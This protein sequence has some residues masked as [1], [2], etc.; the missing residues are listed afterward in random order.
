M[1][2]VVMGELVAGGR[3][4]PVVSSRGEACGFPI[5]RLTL[6][7]LLF[8]LAGWIELAVEGT[9]SPAATLAMIACLVSSL[10]LL[11]SAASERLRPSG[12]NARPTR[13][14]RMS[15]LV[16]LGVSATISLALAVG[17]VIT[18]E[19]SHAYGSDAAAFNHYNAQLVLD[20]VNPYTADNRFWDAVAEFPN[21]GATPLRRGLY[22]GSRLGPSLTQLVRDV[23][24]E[25]AHPDRR[26][27]E[28]DPASLHSYPA[29]AFLVDAPALGLG[30]PTTLPVMLLA[31]VG[32]LCAAAWGAPKVDRLAVWLALL[33]NPILV[34]LT[35]RGSFDVVA[36]LP[37]LLAWRTIERRQVSPILLGLACA[38]KQVVWPLVPFYAIIVWRQEGPREAARRMA[39]AGIAFL[40]PNAT[41]IL[42]SPAAWARSMLLPM[43]LP[44][45]PS[46]LGLIALSR[47]G[48]LPL[49]PGIVYGVLELVALAA[50]L[51]WFARAKRAPRPELA[52][53]LGLLPYLLAWH[54]A[55]SYFAAI[56]VL[57]VY[58][59]LAA[60][61]NYV[62]DALLSERVVAADVADTTIPT[63]PGL[64]PI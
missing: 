9:T 31:L 56:P 7:T 54:S 64:T 58:A 44:I 33:A 57:A 14:V 48:L 59:A 20:G 10:V 8:T 23:R 15:A 46:G 42:A 50:L 5:G 34:L 13:V 63:A 12:G 11:W 27:P 41:F 43:T 24:A 47:V 32:F 62:D 1:G 45:F 16:A 40:I 22:A 18:N 2:V 3:A 29:L 28:F 36:L 25:I 51:L 19:P 53:I 60:R 49:L 37:A 30:L 17:L 21:A 55:T 6:G 35:L 61:R 4:A 39:L 38:V 26:G 52:L